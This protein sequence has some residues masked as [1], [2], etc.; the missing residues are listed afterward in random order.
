MEF[1]YFTIYFDDVIFSRTQFMDL[2]IF[3]TPFKWDYGARSL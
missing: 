3:F 2:F 1:K